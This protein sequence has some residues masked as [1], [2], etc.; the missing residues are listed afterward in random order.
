MEQQNWLTGHDDF[1]DNYPFH[2]LSPRYFNDFFAGRNMGPSIDLHETDREVVLT[3]DIPGIKQEDLDLTVTKDT[4]ILKGETK[5]DESRQGQGYHLSERRYGSFYRV[6][7]LPAEVIGDQATAKYRDGVLELHLPK[8][9][10]GSFKGFKP[11]IDYD[12]T[13]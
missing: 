2:P 9:D 13:H 11:R 5:R 7:Q 6:V 4:V 3:A 10:A 8:A 12:E 1:W